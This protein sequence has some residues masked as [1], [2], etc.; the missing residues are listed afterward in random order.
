[1]GYVTGQRVMSLTL[2]DVGNSQD[3][4]WYASLML[5]RLMFVYFIQRK[6]FLDDNPNYLAERLHRI[7]AEAGTGH[8][9][10]SSN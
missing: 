1:M 7:Q 6:G 10:C 8:F 2:G 4:A 3:Q 5:N 9:C